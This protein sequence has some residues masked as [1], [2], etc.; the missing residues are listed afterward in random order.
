MTLH[1]LLVLSHA[2]GLL[3]LCC[4]SSSVNSSSFSTVARRIMT[5]QIRCSQACSSQN[6]TCDQAVFIKKKST[7]I[8]LKCI[9]GTKCNNIS[10]IDLPKKHAREADHG[11]ST[12]PPALDVRMNG[13]SA[14][15]F[16]SST[17]TTAPVTA[18]RYHHHQ[19]YRPCTDNYNTV[20]YNY[21]YHHNNT[22]TYDYTTY[23]YNTTTYDY[24]TYDYNTTT[25]DY[26]TYDYNTTTYDY[27]TYDYNTTTYDYNTTPYPYHYNTTPYHYNTTTHY[28]SKNNLDDRNERFGHFHVYG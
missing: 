17:T 3:A 6:T 13:T 25:Y 19:Y 22:T 5:N 9:N 1:P 10:V 21:Y 20:V 26:T 7:C 12:H 2:L 4:L 18:N 28:Q 15:I 23:D 14:R 8:F 27:T 16:A 11:H 24:T